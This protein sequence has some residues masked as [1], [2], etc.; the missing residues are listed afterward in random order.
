MHGRALVRAHELELAKV[1]EAEL[2]VR[3]RD[4]ELRRLAAEREAQ[5]ADLRHEPGHGEPPHELQR[6]VPARAVRR[7]HP[8]EEARALE[9]P[10]DHLRLVR[11][12]GDAGDEPPHVGGAEERGL[13]PAVVGAPEADDVVHGPRHEDVGV[14]GVRTHRGDIV[15]VLDVGV[16][17][18]RCRGGAAVCGGGGGGGGN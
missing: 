18:C 14:C 7:A 6:G 13:G 4:E 10:G 11:R 3:A 12:D 2:G 9:R 16:G 17:E 1:V 15:T 8:V 5:D